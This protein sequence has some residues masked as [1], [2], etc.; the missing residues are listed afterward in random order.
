MVNI[1]LFEIHLDDASFEANA[2]FSDA[3][4]E[5]APDAADEY[6]ADVGGGDEGGASNL[7][8]LVVGLVLLIGLAALVRKLRGGGDDDADEADTIDPIDVET[9]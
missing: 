3:E 7:V 4:A 8:A 2:P 9:S 5:D 1:T 6:G